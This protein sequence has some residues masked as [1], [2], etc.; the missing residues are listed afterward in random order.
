MVSLLS[1]F[2]CLPA[3]TK[4]RLANN[5][6]G[7]ILWDP[8]SSALGITSPPNSYTPLRDETLPAE[9][10]GKVFRV[11]CASYW[12]HRDLSTQDFNQLEQRKADPSKAASTSN[13]TLE[14]LL[15]ATD[16]APGDR[17]ETVVMAP[18]FK[19]VIEKQT[20]TLLDLDLRALLNGTK[21]THLFG[22]NCPWSIIYGAWVMES[23]VKE[24]NNPQTHID[25]KVIKGANHFLM[26]DEPEVCM[27]ELLGCMEY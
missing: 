26:W 21:F 24:V 9:E 12:K 16:F 6:K 11:W 13:M 14:Q 18:G 10:R 1:A 19:E 23:R 17:C 20:K 22:D 15:Q 25:F 7:F 4:E 2:N 5:I 27:K 8:P 3:A